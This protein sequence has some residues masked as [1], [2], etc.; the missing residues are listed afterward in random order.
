M[1][2]VL[3]LFC[4]ILL[5][6]LVLSSFS[7]SMNYHFSFHYFRP[8]F[9]SPWNESLIRSI[10]QVL[11]FFLI[12]SVTLFLLI[13]AYSPLTFKVII[14]ECILI[15]NLIHAFHF[16]CSS[17][18]ISSFCFFFCILMICSIFEFLLFIISLCVWILC[19]VLVCGYYEV[20]VHWSRTLYLL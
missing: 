1:D 10:F 7:I 8:V 3:S 9:L 4:L 12:Q 20:Q 14:D 18:F 13:R 6:L 2:F 11:V 16:F 19:I 5:L 15:A 17:L